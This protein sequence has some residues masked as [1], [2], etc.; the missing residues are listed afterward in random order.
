MG[1]KYKPRLMSVGEARHVTN[2]KAD[3]R[4]ISGWDGTI[5]HA[6]QMARIAASRVH[7]RGADFEEL[8]EEA[9]SGVMMR[10]A[11]DP[12][13]S[14]HECIQ[15]GVTAVGD[16]TYML[17]HGRRTDGTHTGER[18]EMYWM[19]KRSHVDNYHLDELALSQVW[20]AM[21][22]DTQKSLTLAALYDTLIDAAQH[23]GVTPVTMRKKVRKARLRAVT[24]WHDWEAPPKL[25]MSSRKRLKTHCNKGHEF[26]TGNTQWITD[27]NG[28][29]QRRCA[30]C[31]R[32]S[33]RR[34]RERQAA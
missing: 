19:D 3:D 14:A 13:S 23:A 16:F 26:T 25:T 32:E 31:N 15:A 34:H 30:T 6:Q 22:E 17:L 24:L 5:Y 28:N 33:Q 8:A 9:L 11:E 27:A 2:D 4:E 10:L 7:F 21:S 29:R 20:E 1:R 12:G 18:K